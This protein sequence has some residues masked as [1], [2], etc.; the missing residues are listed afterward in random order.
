ML[1]T[2]QTE[3]VPCLGTIDLELDY[4]QILTLTSVL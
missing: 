1:P 4:C 2:E 3:D